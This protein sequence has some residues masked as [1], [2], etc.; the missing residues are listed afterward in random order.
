LF[1]ELQQVS[2]NRYHH[3]VRLDSP[4]DALQVATSLANGATAYVTND[5]Q[6]SRLQALLTVVVLDDLATG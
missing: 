4:A 1:F 5:K 6:L 3:E 2:A